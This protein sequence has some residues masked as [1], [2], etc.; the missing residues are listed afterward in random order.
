MV[1]KDNIGLN[2]SLSGG[3]IMMLGAYNFN[4]LRLIFNDEPE[5]CLACDTNVLTMAPTTNVTTTS[6]SN[7]AFPTAVLAKPLIR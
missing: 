3:S 2:Y 1:S 4:I 6:R 5:E 7:S